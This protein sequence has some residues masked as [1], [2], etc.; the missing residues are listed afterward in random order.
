MRLSHLFLNLIR[1][2]GGGV[3]DDVPDGDVPDGGHLVP[4]EDSI[5][6]VLEPETVAVTNPLEL[7]PNNVSK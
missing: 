6:A 3:D 2:D 5:P 4:T 7:I 1:T